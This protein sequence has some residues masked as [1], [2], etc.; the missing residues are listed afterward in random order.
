M[1][2]FGIGMKPDLFKSCCHCRVFQICWHIEYSTFIVSS[3]SIWNSSTGI[4]SP[5]LNLSQ[6]QGLFHWFSSSCQRGKVKPFT[7]DWDLSPCARIQTQPIPSLEFEPTGPGLQPSQNPTWTSNS[8]DRDWNQAKILL[9]T[10][11]HDLSLESLIW[12]LDLLRLRFCLISE[13]IQWKAKW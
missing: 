2:F 13:R 1:P 6:H 10:W 9:G 12:Y 4:P 7:T 11:T 5:P 8:Y 3:F